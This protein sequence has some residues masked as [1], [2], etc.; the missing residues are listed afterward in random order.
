VIQGQKPRG[1]PAIGTGSAKS[2]LD[3]GFEFVF[4]RSR[5]VDFVQS[6]IQFFKVGLT[7]HFC[8]G[9]D[10]LLGQIIEDRAFLQQL[11]QN[12]WILN[13]FVLSQSRNASTSLNTT[14]VIRSCKVGSAIIQAAGMA[15]D[16]SSNSGRRRPTCL[17]SIFKVFPISNHRDQI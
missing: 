12:S 9:S 5:S 15:I 4:L 2:L 7:D 13:F 17:P 11:F 16:Q 8:S 3:F 6:P 1:T 10:A 14:W